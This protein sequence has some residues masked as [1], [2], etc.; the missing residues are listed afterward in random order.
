MGR[1]QTLIRAANPLAGI[2]LVIGM[3]LS[4][5][6]AAYADCPTPSDC[7][8]SV[9]VEELARDLESYSEAIAYDRYSEAEVLAKRIMEFSIILNG[10]ESIDS[11][12]ALT[13]LAF[14][15][16]HLSQ[17]ETARLN[18]EAAIR[19]VEEVDGLL[20]QEL[21]QPLQGLGTTA[22]ASQQTDAARIIFERA[23]HISHVNDGPQN[24]AQIDSLEAIAETYFVAGYIKGSLDIQS[25]IFA[26]KAREFGSESEEFIPALQHHADWM[27]RLNLHNRAKQASRE[28]LRLQE[29]HLGESN[30]EMIP[31][32][33]AL[34]VTPNNYRKVPWD[35]RYH[36]R[37][38][39]PD[40]YLNRAMRIADAQTTSDWELATDTNVAIG[41]YF[42][43]AKRFS[44]ARY[45]YQ[46]AWQQMS[47]DADSLNARHEI[48]EQPKL[49]EDPYLPNFY[50]DQDPIYP[51]EDSD[52][53]LRG[54]ITAEYDISSTGR[55]TNIRL[56]ESQPAGLTGIEMRLVSGLKL[57]LHRP[58]MEE[59]LMAVTPGLKYQYEFFYRE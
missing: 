33:I 34:A 2:L 1:Y 15:Q 55:A 36:G 32:L 39:S 28:I 29:L 5:P 50:D 9:Q 4:M 6:G 49:L 10:L 11:A 47:I 26:L 52:G 22:L 54:T 23:V 13:N 38:T 27:R 8:K 17:Y 35:T 16:L 42:T 57:L 48:L 40:H 44:R 53:Y 21:I 51:P 46:K 3:Q 24:P 7:P 20:S 12:H 37:V 41:D 25:S 19:T 14:V 31:T 43:L 58:R 30:V 59:G 56:V 18:F 45:A